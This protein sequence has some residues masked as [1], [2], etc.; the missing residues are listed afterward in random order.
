[1]II[2]FLLTIIINIL[3]I[4]KSHPVKVNLNDLYYIIDSDYMNKTI[5]NLISLIDGY[6][7]LDIGKNPPND[8]HEKID[9]KKE[10]KSINI[11]GNNTFYEFYREIKRVFAKIKDIHLN[12]IPHVNG[13]FDY[14]ACIPFSF[15][16]NSS[17]NN[18]ITEYYI[19]LKDESINCPF[20][21]NENISSFINVAIQ[22]N[23]TVSKIKGKDPFIFIQEFG[24]EFL[25]LKNNN[26]HFTAA[27]KYISNFPLYYLPLNE[28]E[29]NLSIELSNG[30]QCT[31]PY[32]LYLIEESLSYT[33]R[34]FKKNSNLI[35]NY[36][37]NGFKCRV[38]EIN[39]VNVF[40]Q[41]TFSF[42]ENQNITE[43]IYNCSK[44]FH[45]NK[46]K[47]IGIE[48]RN[49]GGDGKISVYLQQ[50]LQPKISTN[51]ILFSMRKNKF[52]KKNFGNIK[53]NYLDFST[54][55]NPESY[56]G[57][58]PKKPDNHGND[59]THNRTII[60][61]AINLNM[62]KDLEEKREKL[63]KTKNT[64]KPTDIIIFT[65]YDSISAASLFIKGFQ[66]TGGAIVVGYF[67]NPYNNNL[68]DSSVSSSGAS[69]YDWTE[70]YKNLI[71]LN[72][73]IIIT[74]Q[75]IFGYNYNDKN[76][77][78]QEYL[79]YNVDSHVNI[80]E[81]YNDDIYHLFIE[82]AKYIFDNYSN[83]CNINNKFL[84]LENSK[85]KEINGDKN[86]HG[87]FSCGSDSKWNVSNCKAFYCDL[88]YY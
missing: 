7:Y 78:P 48:S 27:I 28:T 55:K 67:G 40:V 12:L 60:F 32:N 70:E 72:F 81:D 46:Y 83:Y 29:L 4:I 37:T 56:D 62:K 11:K 44:L 74:N 13:T 73:S 19:Y 82:E 53:K 25:S 17:I 65:D 50:L 16:I 18:N 2:F 6:V 20:D 33:K 52:I 26:S 41:N 38:D 10:L 76:P 14:Y 1:M 22:E 51:K 84:L 34:D 69:L 75:E 15:N 77:I 31:I 54:C 24:I 64:K 30:S 47:I 61:D 80:Y 35:W 49:E 45:S 9:L 8:M 43:L 3:N 36:S 88:G 86:K 85:C 79:K 21:Y 68:S 42:N 23:L 57:I 5:S 87:G 39:Q 63:I 71:N 59:I 58:F 66:Q